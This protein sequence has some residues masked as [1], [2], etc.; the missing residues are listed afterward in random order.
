MNKVINQVAMLMSNNDTYSGNYYAELLKEFLIPNKYKDQ[1]NK[2]IY[3]I[4]TYQHKLQYQ[5]VFDQL[6]ETELFHKIGKQQAL[7]ELVSLMISLGKTEEEIQ[8]Q[9]RISTEI[10]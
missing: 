3:N 2:C 4:S 5:H 9:Q 7:D 6:Y 8:Q 10:L 1:Y